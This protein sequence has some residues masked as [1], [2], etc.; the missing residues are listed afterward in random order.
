MRSSR[1]INASS[2]TKRRELIKSRNRFQ[3]QLKVMGYADLIETSLSSQLNFDEL[4]FSFITIAS[5]DMRFE[6][7][8]ISSDSVNLS[9]QVSSMNGNY[10]F[11]SYLQQVEQL[12]FVHSSR[13]NLGVASLPDTSR[14]SL[15]IRLEND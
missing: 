5:S 4:L 15:N 8:S 2:D 12:P 9:G 11:Y 3:D 13:Y 6:K 14:F 7:L 10:S 1:G